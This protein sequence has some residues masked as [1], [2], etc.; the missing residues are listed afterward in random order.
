MHVSGCE[1]PA[2]LVYAYEPQ[3]KLRTHEVHGFPKAR[4]A[5]VATIGQH[6]K[7]WNRLPFLVRVEDFRGAFRP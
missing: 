6:G 4:N 2:A 5:V 7:S 3:T 1:P